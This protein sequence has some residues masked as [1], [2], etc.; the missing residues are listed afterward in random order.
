MSAANP[1]LSPQIFADE[2]HTRVAS[3]IGIPADTL[4]TDADLTDLGLDSVRI[5]DIVE[6]AR[7]QGWDAEFAD[8]IENPTLDAWVDAF[9]ESDE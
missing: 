3:A 6:W 5:I 1:P 2:L 8:L 4:E 9:E 7:R